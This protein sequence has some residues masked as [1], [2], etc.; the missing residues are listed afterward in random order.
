[1]SLIKTKFPRDLMASF[2]NTLIKLYLDFGN[3]KEI[4]FLKYLP[5]IYVL[6]LRENQIDSLSGVENLY[7]LTLICFD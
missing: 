3:V 1:M 2:S 6:F 7:N 4:T 5:N